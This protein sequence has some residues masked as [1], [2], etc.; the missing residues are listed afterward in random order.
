[1]KEL[2]LKLLSGFALVAV[3]SRYDVETG[4]I[5]LPQFLRRQHLFTG[6]VID[7]NFSDRDIRTID[8]RTLKG[9]RVL[10]EHHLG[11]HLRDNL[12]VVPVCY[13]VKTPDG[14]KVKER[15]CT[16]LAYG[17]LVPSITGTAGERKRCRFCGP[18]KSELS[19]N[20]PY[21]V[22]HARGFW[23][24]PRCRKNECGDKVDPNDI[25]DTET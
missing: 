1:M 19:Q 14:K 5:A 15:R 23:Y 8:M 25:V 3:D 20:N 17:D 24:C 10:L 13:E 12:Y 11:R 2:A 22:P 18:A 4:G 9:Q 7:D 21:L 16:F 6:N